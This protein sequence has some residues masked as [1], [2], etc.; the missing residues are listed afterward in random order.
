MDSGSTDG[1]VELLERVGRDV[2]AHRAGAV[3]PRQT[4]NLG[5]G[6]RGRARRADRAGRAAASEHWLAKL[7]APLRDDARGR[8]VRAAGAAAGAPARSTRSLSSLGGAPACRARVVTCRAP[9]ELRRAAPIERLRHC[10]FDNV[11][12]LHSAQRLG[13]SIP[14]P[15]TPIAEDLEWGRTCC[16]PGYSLA[17]VPE[18][19]VV[20][21]HERS[22][23]Y[24]L[25]RTCLLHQQ[26][27]ELFGLRTI[28]TPRALLPSIGAT[29]A[30][31]AAR[32]RCRRHS[33]VCRWR[34][35]LALA[36][37]WP[38]GQYLGGCRRREGDTRPL[39]AGRLMRV[40]VVVHGFPPHAHGR[41]RDLR[42][43]AR[44]VLR[45]RTATMCSCSR[46]EHDSGR[47]S[48]VVRL[49]RRDGIESAGSTTRS[50]P[51]TAST[52]PTATRPSRVAAA[53]FIDEWRPDVAHVHHLTCLS[54]EILDE[55]ARRRIP[56]VYT[57]HD[58]WLICHRGQLLDRRMQRCD[59]PGTDGC[60]NCTGVES[61]APPY[62]YAG[63][64]L[65]N[66]LERNCPRESRAG[67]GRRRKRPAAARNTG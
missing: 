42:P 33:G 58:Y 62:A 54:T 64:R 51:R 4:R 5:V 12:V 30:P 11:C 38:L 1:T 34:R 21:S 36:V 18:A 63:G 43:R 53:R 3:Q 20:H 28:P 14:F 13:S 27:Y 47:R 41:R 23:R 15:P 65:L 40:L 26:L 50:G 67:C 44:G 56:V 66:Q 48:Y 25:A 55:L 35:A 59:G 37:A 24:E 61:L 19:V 39:A 57:L 45:G 16:W 49:E 31:I 60:G 52:R 29:I 2:I 7:V 46:A 6:A 22:A 17:Y 8:H 10:T 32:P 9:L